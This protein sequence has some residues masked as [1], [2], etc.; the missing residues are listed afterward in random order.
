METLDSLLN[1]LDTNQ[2]PN[3]TASKSSETLR[4]LPQSGSALQ[5]TTEAETKRN[6]LAAM[7]ELILKSLEL[8]NQAT[9]SDDGLDVRG[10]AWSEVLFN[11]VPCEDLKPAFNQAFADNKT[12]FPISAQM[13]AQG[14]EVLTQKRKYERIKDSQANNK[15][16]TDCPFCFNSG[17]CG[18]SPENYNVPLNSHERA[19][20]GKMSG[21]RHCHCDY[22]ERRK[23]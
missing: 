11:I 16:E 2:Q 23:K 3:E 9:L 8:S 12:N 22:W 14:Y 4:H 15:S 6:Y 20:F 19:K 18:V 21:V 5:K 17:F 10:L 13:I 1:R 7:K